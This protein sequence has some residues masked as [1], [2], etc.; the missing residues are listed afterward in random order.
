MKSILKDHRSSIAVEYALIAPILILLGLGAIEFSAAVR[1][2]LN[3]DQ[4][5]REVSTMIAATPIPYGSTVANINYLQLQ[6]FYDAAIDCNIAPSANLSI[7]AAEVNFTATNTTGTKAWDASTAGTSPAYT[8]MPASALT[9][10]SG[11]GDTVNNDGVIIVQVT[12]S[13]TLPFLP[14]FFGAIPMGPF[15]SVSTVVARPRNSLTITLNNGLD[16]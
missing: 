15:S 9:Q 14:S 7:S 10:A 1:V 12:T 16:M 6:D 13:Y 5:A 11:L 2:Q 8:A 4:I 3:T